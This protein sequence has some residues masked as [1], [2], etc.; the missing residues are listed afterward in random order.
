M[1]GGYT[2]FCGSAEK[3][4][5]WGL[6]QQEF[7][8]QPGD[9]KCGMCVCVGGAVSRG[10]E[11]EPAPASPAPC[12]PATWA[13]LAWLRH[14]SPSVSTRWSCLGLRLMPKWSLKKSP[15]TGLGHPNPA[16]AHLSLPAPAKTP[17][18][19]KV[20]HRHRPLGP[21]H[22]RGRPLY[23]P[24]CHHQPHPPAPISGSHQAKETLPEGAVCPLAY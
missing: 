12:R 11:A 7:C 6:K 16:C 20:G 8:P 24:Q 14:S 4:R 10:S 18:P 3:T 5:N 22:D 2:G 17:S 13:L 21:K 15:V 1:A 19:H 23:P 9:Q